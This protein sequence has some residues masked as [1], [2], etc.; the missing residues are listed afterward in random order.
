[1]KKRVSI[2]NECNVNAAVS[3]H[4]NSYVSA[5]SKGAQVFYYKASDEGKNWRQLYR[6]IC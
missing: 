4:Q 2:I 3:I 5:E 6:R 1:M